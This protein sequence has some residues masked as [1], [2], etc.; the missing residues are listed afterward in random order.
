[1]VEGD[2]MEGATI[3]SGLLPDGTPHVEVNEVGGVKPNLNGDGDNPFAGID[4]AVDASRIPKAFQSLFTKYMECEIDGFIFRYRELSL[5]D[6]ISV[7]GN[8]FLEEIIHIEFGDD[9]EANRAL[10]EERI[11]SI[12]NVSGEEEAELNRVTAIHRDKVILL[13]LKSIRAGE[14]VFDEIT[15]EIIMWLQE[16]VREELYN[17][18]LMANLPNQE[19]EAVRRFPDESSDDG[20]ETEGVDDSSSS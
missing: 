19:N 8:P 5:A 10:F 20:G 16:R 13:S 17:V 12:M 11:T 4:T 1:M 18:I 15:P 7:G 14:E 3:T 9:D 6:V 2:V